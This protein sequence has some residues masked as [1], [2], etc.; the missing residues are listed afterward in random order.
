MEKNYA[1][2]KRGS[3]AKLVDPDQAYIVAEYFS[4]ICTGY[5]DVLTV[6]DIAHITGL[7]KKSLLKLLKAGHIKSIECSPR[8]LV[9]KLY[10][11]EFATTK[12]FREIRTNS[13]RFNEL[14]E[15]FDKWKNQR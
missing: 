2:G 8:Y 6:L 10:F 15:E 9:P 3:F 1:S 5:K 12:R 13:D 4:H 14:L 11:L 7:N